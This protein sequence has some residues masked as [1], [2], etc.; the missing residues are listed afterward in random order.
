ME[1]FGRGFE[2]GNQ[3]VD[4]IAFCDGV[5]IASFKTDILV[6]QEEGC[7]PDGEAGDVE[8]GKAF[9]APEAAQ[10]DLEIVL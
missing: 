2:V 10:G 8:D 3:A 9:M 4:A 6:D 5:V 1:G 7:H